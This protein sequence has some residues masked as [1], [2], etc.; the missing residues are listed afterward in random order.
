V[1]CY[2]VKQS[3]YSAQPPAGCQGGQFCVSKLEQA[4][5]FNYKPVKLAPWGGF[6]RDH[7]VLREAEQLPGKPV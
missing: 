7:W 3:N 5:V 4:D 1:A 6:A 2:F